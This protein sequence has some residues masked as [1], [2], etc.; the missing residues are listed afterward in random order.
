MVASPYRV[1]GHLL[2]RPDGVDKVTGEAR[3]AADYATPGTLMGKTLHSPY[4]HARIVS[5][6]VSA[7]R[8]LPGVHAVITAADIEAELYGRAIKDIPVLATDRVRYIGERIAAVA[9]DDEDIAQQAVDLIEVEYEELPAVFEVEE[10]LA[11][12]A[13]QLHPDFPS[14]RGG[15][16]LPEPSNAY[17]TSL[18]ENTYY[19]QRQHQAYLEPQTVMMEVDGDKVNVWACSKA[20]YDTRNAL[21]VSVQIEPD[22]LVFNH[23]YIGGD[24]GG[25]ATPANLPIVYF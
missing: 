10:A 6:D 14:Y 25:K 5:I 15:K 23:T 19:T 18:V 3:Y 9:A 7:A 1:I 8:A 20:P 16:E 24:F 11:A 2:P 4:A 17:F 22:D 12:G 21:G 13:P